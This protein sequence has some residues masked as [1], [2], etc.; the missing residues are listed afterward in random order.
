MTTLSDE[1]R[2]IVD[3]VAEFVD[4]EVRP[5]ARALEHANA[6]PSRLIER[7]NTNEIQR[8]VIVR[9]LIDRQR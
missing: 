3:V 7:M 6:Y 8:N 9:Q 4:R 2:A 5:N 1:E